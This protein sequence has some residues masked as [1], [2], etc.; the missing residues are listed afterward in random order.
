MAGPLVAAA[1]PA[2]LSARYREVRCLTERLCDP[3]AVEDY[4][5][6]SMPDCSPP[7]W[8]L[9]HTTWFFEAFA[10]S[11]H[12]AHYR[13][14]HPWFNY[15]FNSYYD[16]VG[17]RWPRPQRGLLSRPTVAEV[18]AYRRHVDHG[19]E[20]LFQPARRALLEQVAD[21]LVV[22]LNHEQQHQELIVTDVK[23]ALA[24]NP[25]HPVYRHRPL[26]T[27]RSAPAEWT[28]FP[29]DL[30]AIGHDGDC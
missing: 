8:H 21:A 4:Q 10:L 26:V 7:K 29:A 11:S 2:L 13:P 14:Y 25:L 15:L 28:A 22:G 17:A 3:L 30:V 18:Y 27:G 12:A 24:G 20:A 1:D 19:M 16:T 23:H 5:L 9:A 6:Q